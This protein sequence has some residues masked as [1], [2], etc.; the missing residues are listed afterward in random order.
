[1]E[2]FVEPQIRLKLVR[3]GIKFGER[4]PQR[5][6]EE[7]DGAAD[8]HLRCMKELSAKWTIK[9]F[10]VE[11]W[12][13]KILIPSQKGTMRYPFDMYRRNTHRRVTHNDVEHSTAT[14]ECD[15]ERRG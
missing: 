11:D 5:S 4:D 13:M 15:R 3:A 10:I 1:M 2:I 12:G 8:R 7:L 14:L 6:A 9:S